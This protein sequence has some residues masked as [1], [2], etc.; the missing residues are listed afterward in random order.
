L[1]AFT[2]GRS[3]RGSSNDGV[4]PLKNQIAP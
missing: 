4:A 2:T 3:M 1:S